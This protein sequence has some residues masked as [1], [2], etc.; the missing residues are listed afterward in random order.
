[1]YGLIRARVSLISTISDTD[2]IPFLP[3][4]LTAQST[5]EPN[6]GATLDTGV[7]LCFL[8]LFV[9]PEVQSSPHLSKVSR[10]LR[11]FTLWLRL[12]PTYHP[13]SIVFFFFQNV[14]NRR[15]HHC[16]GQTGHVAC[17]CSFECQGE[18][19][20]GMFECMRIQR[21]AGSGATHHRTVH[22]GQLCE[23]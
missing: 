11:K 15:L 12:L 8:R 10:T 16:S 19:P 17:I 20:V 13:S 7:V 6:Y 3:P 2:N 22:I 18:Y 23:Q 1:M 4:S 5:L 21:R 14:T 9:V